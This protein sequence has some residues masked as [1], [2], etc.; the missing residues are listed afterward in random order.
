VL[1]QRLQMKV[2]DRR[3]RIVKVLAKVR[4]KF[5]SEGSR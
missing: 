3:Y 5:W 4:K 2:S 1:L